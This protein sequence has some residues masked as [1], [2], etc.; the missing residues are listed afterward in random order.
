VFYDGRFNEPDAGT[1]F[2]R[3]AVYVQASVIINPVVIQG[4]DVAMI[5]AR[6]CEIHPRYARRPATCLRNLTP[7][8]KTL[9]NSLKVLIDRFQKSDRAIKRGVLREVV[10]RVVVHENS[11]IEVQWAIS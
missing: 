10:R 9:K 8:A 1:R 3:K 4:M 7:D 5:T 2:K 6:T 11:Q